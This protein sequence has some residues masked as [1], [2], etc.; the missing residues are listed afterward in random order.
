[1]QLDIHTD[2]ARVHNDTENTV[3]KQALQRRPPEVPEGRAPRVDGARPVLRAS[4]G[5]EALSDAAG[6][7]TAS[8]EIPNDCIEPAGESMGVGT[9]E[10]LA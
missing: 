9:V 6:S 5:T 10:V 2:F 4:R 7:F 8:L 3:N 1:M